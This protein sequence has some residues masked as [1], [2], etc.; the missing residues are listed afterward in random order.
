MSSITYKNRV[1]A[2][3]S[4]L[5][6]FRVLDSFIDLRVLNPGVGYPEVTVTHDISSWKAGNVIN[7]ALPNAVTYRFKKSS[8]IITKTVDAKHLNVKI[9]KH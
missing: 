1:I 7:C 8:S 9:R 5:V 2:S 4:R 6:P 3:V